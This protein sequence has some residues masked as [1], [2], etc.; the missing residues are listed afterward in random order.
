[1]YY[2][3][4]DV[5]DENSRKVRKC[6]AE[7]SK[8]EGIQLEEHIVRAYRGEVDYVCRNTYDKAR[9]CG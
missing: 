7:G 4:C 5:C 8:E 9:K 3:I 2:N 6:R 1:M